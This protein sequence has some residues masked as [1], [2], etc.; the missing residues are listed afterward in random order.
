[1]ATNNKAS[2]ITLTLA[3]VDRM[4]HVINNAYNNSIAKFT[5]MQ[6]KV[7]DM[8]AASN[9]FAQQTGIMGGAMAASLA[10]PVK[11]AI[12][13]ET[14]MLGIAKQVEGA[15]D[16]SGNLTAVYHNMSKEVKALT[17]E[18]PMM[19]DEI[20]RMVAAGARMGIV[21]DEL[22]LFTKNAAKMSTAFEMPADVLADQMGKIAK[23]YGVPI[24]QINKLAD[25][26]NFLDD[27]AIAKGADIIDVMQRIGGTAQMLKLPGTNAAALASTFLTL[28]ETAETAGTAANALMRELAIAS[29][30]PA[31]FQKGMAALGL[32]SGDIQRSMSKD[33]QG[34]ILKVLD[35]INK[36]PETQKAT[37]TSQLFGDMYFKQVAKLAG[38]VGEYRRQLALLNDAKLVGSMDREFAARMQTTEAQLTLVSAQIRIAAIN[39]GT[40]LLP[41]LKAILSVVTPV[42]EWFAEFSENNP[43][44]SATIG[45]LIGTVSAFFLLLSGF[46]FIASGVVTAFGTIRVAMRLMRAQTDLMIIRWLYFKASVLTSVPWLGTAFTAIGTAARAMW[47][48]IS[49]PIGWV[50]LAIAAVALVVY[51]YWDEITGYFKNT[52]WEQIGWDLVNGL[53]EGIKMFNL[54]GMVWNL[55]GAISDTFKKVLGIASPSK[56]FIEHGHN[57]A[58]EIG[59][60]HV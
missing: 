23:L 32:S 42:V 43:V 31:Q 13:Y 51:Y 41:A 11:S 53:W 19:P 3:A 1:M 4:S 9:R 25:A 47:A 14:A 10:L 60:A 21:N 15:R 45:I 52:S 22:I 28:G 24:P 44:L 46:G 16:A 26:I 18:L 29:R 55:A 35:A 49:G 8:A 6:S 5:K 33:A 54:L 37:V 2:Q 38:G 20:A 7:N 27:N 39:F 50:I 30:Q 34:T 56:V 48:A 57:I 58:K 59:R 40:A 12:E 17:K 36:L